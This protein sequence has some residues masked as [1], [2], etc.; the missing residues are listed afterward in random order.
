VHC[1]DTQNKT[2]SVRR[3]LA[4]T[5]A[6]SVALWLAG[7]SLSGPRAPDGATSGSVPPVVKPPV[8]QLRARSWA[9]YQLWAAKRIVAVNP[10]ITHLGDVEQPAM[11][12]PVIEV[13]LR[14]DGSIQKINV[15]RYPS[16]NKETTQ[17]AIDAIKR[18]APFGDV[19]HLPKPWKFNEVFLF[20]WNGRFKPRT[21][22]Q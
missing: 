11:A 2:S 6:G 14:A 3:G 21:L 12:I 22:D 9:E 4:W 20:N 8:S 16:Q 15:M 10:D 18:A 19:S 1:I 17:V 7:C 13:E 5:L